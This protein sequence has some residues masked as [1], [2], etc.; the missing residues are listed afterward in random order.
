MWMLW[1]ILAGIAVG[2]LSGLL[3]VAGGFVLVPILIYLFK[4]EQK[5]AQG[6]SLAILLPPT[7][8]LAFLSY[9]QRGEA[10]L[11]LGL[12]V[13]VGVIVGGYFGGVW[14]QHVPGPALRKA[15]AVALVILGI[16]MFFEK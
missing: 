2:I 9:Y 3:G 13:A 8:I 12:V 7:G 1:G 6:T 15:F 5:L 10:N 4:M 14:A 11:K 16:K